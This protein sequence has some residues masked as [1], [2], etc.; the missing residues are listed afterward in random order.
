MNGPTNLRGGRVNDRAPSRAQPGAARAR[1]LVIALTLA[2]AVCA[3]V[4]IFVGGEARAVFGGTAFVI[5]LAATW[6]GIEMATVEPSDPQL[7]LEVPPPAIELPM[8]P[9]TQTHNPKVSSDTS[10]ERVSEE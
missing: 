1:S 8:S 10:L 2:A 9:T 5:G 6:G 7:D 3:L 4:A